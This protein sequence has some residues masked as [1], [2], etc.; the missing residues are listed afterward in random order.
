M[1]TPPSDAPLPTP[2]TDLPPTMPADDPF[3]DD[4]ETEVGPPPAV[5]SKPAEPTVPSLSP[6]GGASVD[7]GLR[8]QVASNDDGPTRVPG[9]PAAPDGGGQEPRLLETLGEQTAPSPLPEAAPRENPLRRGMTAAFSKAVVPTASESISQ[10]EMP[11]AVHKAAARR[12]NPLRG[13]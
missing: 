11:T 4:P 1:P 8:W 2:D 12:Q 13:K 5:P 9:L 10:Q 3:K 6:S 7:K